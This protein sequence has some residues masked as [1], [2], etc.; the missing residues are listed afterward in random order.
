M[1]GSGEAILA[2]VFSLIGALL[3]VGLIVFCI[4]RRNATRHS[5]W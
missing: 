2:A 1:D 5:P 3:L 4:Y